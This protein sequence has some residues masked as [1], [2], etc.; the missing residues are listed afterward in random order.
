[1]PRV[2][3]KSSAVMVITMIR[4]ESCATPART[5]RGG[6]TAGLAAAIVAVALDQSVKYLVVLLVPYGTEVQVLPFLSFL[7]VHNTGIAFSFFNDQNPVMLLVVST[8]ITL[9]LAW[10]W[11]KNSD[12]ILLSVAYGSILGGAIG[13]IIDRILRGQVVDFIFLH[14]RSWTFA[15]FNLADSA[16][17]LGVALILLSGILPSGGQDRA[18]G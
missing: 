1:M 11:L 4:D 14:W 8:S 18:P 3:A 12:T 9:L 15:I 6:A 10:F 5:T 2:H 7:H 17:T 13:N 16:I